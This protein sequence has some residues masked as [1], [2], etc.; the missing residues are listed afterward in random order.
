MGGTGHPLKGVGR[1]WRVLG[2]LARA[3]AHVHARAHTHWRAQREGWVG[4]VRV[5]RGK[6]ARRAAGPGRWVVTV[7][8]GDG[9]CL[10]R[11]P[12]TH[13]H[14]MKHA[15]AQGDWLGIEERSR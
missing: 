1:A 11:A 6:L 5:A 3:R 7:L 10:G 14:T 2:S 9:A 15:H 13:A 4:M 12:S 8:G